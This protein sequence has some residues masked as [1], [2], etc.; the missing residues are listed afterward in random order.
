[1]KDFLE[2]NDAYDKYFHNIEERSIK[3]SNSSFLRYYMKNLKKQVSFKELSQN[4]T[5]RFISMYIAEIIQAAC[6]ITYQNIYKEK[7]MEIFEPSVEE[8]HLKD[9]F[10]SIVLELLEP[11][12]NGKSEEMSDGSYA[13]FEL[14]AHVHALYMIELSND[15]YDKQKLQDYKIKAHHILSLSANEAMDIF[16]KQEEQRLEES[17][18][19]QKILDDQFDK[20][21]NERPEVIEFKQQQEKI[22]QQF[23]EIVKHKDNFQKISNDDIKQF[24]NVAHINETT[25]DIKI[26]SKLKKVYQQYF[27]YDEENFNH[28]FNDIYD[29]YRL[30]SLSKRLTPLNFFEYLT[31]LLLETDQ[32]DTSDVR[33]IELEIKEYCESAQKITYDFINL[34]S[35]YLWHVQDIHQRQQRIKEFEKITY[36]ISECYQLFLEIRN[37]EDNEKY[38]DYNSDVF[39]FTPQE[40]YITQMV[41]AIL[42]NLDN[43]SVSRRVKRLILTQYHNQYHLEMKSKELTRLYENGIN[44]ENM[45][46]I[47]DFADLFMMSYFKDKEAVASFSPFVRCFH[48]LHIVYGISLGS[49]ESIIQ[50]CL[51]GTYEDDQK[52]MKKVIEVNKEIDIFIDKYHQNNQLLDLKNYRNLEF[53]L[54]NQHKSYHFYNALE[55]ID[56]LIQKYRNQLLWNIS[57]YHEDF[58]EKSLDEQVDDFLCQCFIYSYI[59]EIDSY[60]NYMPKR[61]QIEQQE[62]IHSL[63]KVIDDKE[64]II[65]IKNQQLES[66]SLPQKNNKKYSHTSLLEQE[67]NFYKQQVSLLNKDILKK[68]KEIDDLKNNQQEL[69]KLRELF[70]SMDQETYEE[71]HERVDLQPLLQNQTIIM[72]GGHIALRNKMKQK[73]PSIKV[74]SQSSHISD[75][76]LL[77]ADYVFMFHK[78]MTHDMYNRAISVLTR[79]HIP[80]DYIPYTNLEKSE[81]M[82]HDIL[83]EKNNS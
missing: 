27:Q 39:H 66:L 80:W 82:I 13:K 58:F 36:E 10:Q 29:K 64:N 60:E 40:K 33:L 61:H 1:M 9:T 57:I 79:N 11:M 31:F 15:D 67:L 42:L 25:T 30:I 71:T 70:F 43:P 21:Y 62:Y 16:D 38:I 18:L 23:Q 76:V 12:L 68:E 54:F 50:S 32:I 4:S 19:R 45:T 56:V 51:Q 2:R 14:Y 44:D 63:K 46:I 75:A 74:L 24:L 72:I 59:D 37:E 3:A 8:E 52:L 20:E 47:S 53:I 34:L 28:Y 17:Q 49:Y 73:Y 81:K 5:K 77:N 78:F 35:Y 41:I 6:F 7:Y 69:Y 26:I 48:D 22:A 83:L 55:N 65:Q